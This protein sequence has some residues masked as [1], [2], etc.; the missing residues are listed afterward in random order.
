M[1]LRIPAAR[2]AGIAPENMYGGGGDPQIL[3]RLPVGRNEAAERA[4][5]LRVGAHLQYLATLKAE[6]FERPPIRGTQHTG[7]MCVVDKDGAPC[8]RPTPVCRVA[9]RYRRPC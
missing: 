8:G 3:G 7:R 5:R 1:A 4:E 2:H 6:V 9:A